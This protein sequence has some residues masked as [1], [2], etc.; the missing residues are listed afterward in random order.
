MVFERH[1]CNRAATMRVL[2]PGMKESYFGRLAWDLVKM[3]PALLDENSE[4]GKKFD[5]FRALKQAYLKTSDSREKVR[6]GSNS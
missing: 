5:Q 1:K 6:L 4:E 3:N 2:F